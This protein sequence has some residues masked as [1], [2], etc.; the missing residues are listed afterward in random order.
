MLRARPAPAA[1]VAAF[2]GA[3]SARIVARGTV[4]LGAVTASFTYGVAR[5][6]EPRV[7][8]DPLL[9]A[10]ELPPPAAAGSKPAAAA[11]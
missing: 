8:L 11:R 5:G 2:V 7:T 10:V 6:L 3:E 4:P 9:L 1:D